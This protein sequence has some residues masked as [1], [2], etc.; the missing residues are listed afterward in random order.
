LSRHRSASARP[1]VVL[2]RWLHAPKVRWLAVVSTVLVLL[3]IGEYRTGPDALAGVPTSNTAVTVDD[4]RPGSIM[5][6][7]PLRS[8]APEIEAVSARSVR[9]VYR[10]TEARTGSLTSV[11]GSVYVPKGT[12]PQGGWPV[13]AIGHGGSGI[14]EDCA[15]SLSTTLLGEAPLV[16]TLLHRGY[17]V[18]LT[19]YQGLG[20]PDTVHGYLDAATAGRN[21]IDSVRALRGIFP[22]VSTQ[23]ATIGT[24]QGG[25]AAWAADQQAAGYAADLELVGAIALS[26]TTDAS[27]LV[28][29]AHNGTLTVSQRTTLLWSLASL[30]RLHPEL[31]LD[32]Y[33]R[34][35]A[36]RQ[37]DALTACS[38]A[39]VHKGT[40]AARNLGPRDLAPSTDESADALRALMREFAI[41]DQPLTAPLSVVLDADATAVEHRWTMN[42]INHACIAGG[43]IA[44]RLQRGGDGAITPPDQIDWLAERFAGKPAANLCS[45]GSVSGPAAGMV[46]HTEDI[47]DVSATLPPG[48]HAARV[49]YGS[50]RADTGAATVVSGTVFA[51][52]GTPPPGGWPVIAYGHGT[53]GIYE[54][55]APSLSSTLLLQAPAVGGLLQAGFA[56][57]FADYEGLGAPGIHPYLD[58]RTAGLNVIDSVRA[59]RATFPDVSERWAAIGHSQGGAAVWAAD[60]QAGTYAPELDLVGAV[61]VAPAADVTGIVDKAVDGTLTPEQLATLQTLLTSMERVYPDFDADDFRRGTAVGNW[62]LVGPCVASIP[63]SVQTGEMASAP[64]QAVNQLSWILQ[65][66]ALPQRQLSAPLSI[67]YGTA[68]QYVDEQWTTDAITRACAL[69]DSMNFRLQPEKGHA[70]LDWIGQL[71]W[72][73]DRFQGMPITSDCPAP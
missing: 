36:A 24:G 32:D 55:C 53:T 11:S 14:D 61:A 64:T 33:R 9:V 30:S 15:P 46:L 52:A 73:R 12:A 20:V 23:W 1:S 34:G 68:D 18:S 17:A 48:S 29:S 3:G 44:W 6:V 22:N 43:T 72:L 7:S 42:S 16:A 49:L 8:L 41:T 57:A 10:S 59:L 51:P 62:G 38:G 35:V 63:E 39:L 69:G 5:S 50:T 67:V 66:W 37:W 25:G 27:G 26:P 2:R 60:E 31:D 28:D 58:S 56:V 40:V 65:R 45:S 47:P 70:D 21:V 4:S 54:Q 71:Y 19:D 13:V